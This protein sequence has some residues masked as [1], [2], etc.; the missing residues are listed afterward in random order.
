MPLSSP[1][2]LNAIQNLIAGSAA[3]ALGLAVH[4]LQTGDELLL[5]ADDAFHAASTFKVCV[6]MEAYHQAQ[7]GTLSLEERLPVRNEF[8]SLVDG[9]P[10]SLTVE[11]DGETDLYRHLGECLPLSDLV[12]RMIIRSSNLATNLLVE[13]LGAERITAFMLALGAP[14]LLVRRGVEDNKA[15]ALGLNNTATARSLMHILVRLAERTVVSRPASDEMIA[16]L[17]Q[18]YYNEGIPAGLPAGTVVAHKTGWNDKLYHDAAIVFPKRRRPYVLV[19]MTR[20]L[21][22]DGAGPALVAALAGTIHT[23]LTSRS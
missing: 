3:A 2:F 19:A 4:D 14:G 7:G 16:I 6:M 9:S 13:K 23:N 20:G 21:A 15:Y 18:Q 11:D 22:E 8:R 12:R 10:F 5:R 17:K 1:P